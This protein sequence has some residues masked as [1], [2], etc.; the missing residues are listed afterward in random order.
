MPSLHPRQRV[1][2]PRGPTPTN[3]PTLAESS[4]PQ[5]CS[6]GQQTCSPVSCSAR[7]SDSL[8]MRGQCRGWDRAPVGI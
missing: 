7:L 3:D 2:G 8:L 6:A 5:I 4:D 1:D